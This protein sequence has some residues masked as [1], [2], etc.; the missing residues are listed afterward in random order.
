MSYFNIE[1]FQQERKLVESV[2]RREM[3]VSFSS[4]QMDVIRVDVS[5]FIHE[6]LEK[7]CS[8]ADYVI[9]YSTDK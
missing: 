5:A 2:C 1:G 4:S 6:D 9:A 3:A 8:V 7:F